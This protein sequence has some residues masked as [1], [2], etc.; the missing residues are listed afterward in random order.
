M[1]PEFESD[2]VTQLDS[3]RGLSLQ[4]ARSLAH[5]AGFTEAGIVALPHANEARDADR[6]EQWIHAGHSGSMHY[7]ART[8]NDNS[9]LVRAR[10]SNP[11]PWARSAI[12]C[13]ANYNSSQPRSVN[14]APPNSGWIAR[15]AWS[16]RIDSSGARRPSDYHKVLLKRLKS[17]DAKLR[18]KFGAFESRAYVDTGPIV[19]RNL[20]VAAGLGWTGKNTCLIHPKIGSFVFLAVL[21]TSL[22][23]DPELRALK[24]PDRCGTCTRCLDACPTN[25][26]MAPYKMDATRCIAYLTIE[27]RGP[28]DEQLMNGMGRQVFGCD[29]CQDVCPWNRKAPIA[30]DAELEPR[31]ELVNPALEWLAGLDESDFERIFNGSPVRRAGFNGLRR[32]LAVAMANSGSKHLATQLERWS[33]AA[34]QGLQAAARWALRKLGAAGNID[35]DGEKDVEN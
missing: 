4:I 28:L 2:P 7:L 27:H 5:D 24:V 30:A 19:E 14:N 11:F 34:D 29:I 3:P 22:E 23:V 33:N 13:L 17:L 8:C 31:E 12:V 35:P 15:Y 9:E 21:L 26:F 32:N 16:S 6:F 20:A 1:K 10:V 18:E 25:A